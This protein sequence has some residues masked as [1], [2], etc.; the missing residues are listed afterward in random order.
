MQQLAAAVDLDGS[1]NAVTMSVE[2]LARV[3]RHRHI[4]PGSMQPRAAGERVISASLNVAEG[5]V[6]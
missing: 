4:T 2:V 6:L 5:I 1:V 3:D